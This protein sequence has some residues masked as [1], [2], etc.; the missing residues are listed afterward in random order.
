MQGRGPA[1]GTGASG[2][3]KAEHLAEVMLQ[4]G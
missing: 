1:G 3:P 4:G 2:D